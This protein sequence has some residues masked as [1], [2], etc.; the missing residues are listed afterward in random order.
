MGVTVA[1]VDTGISRSSTIALGRDSFVDG[2][3]KKIQGAIK[4]C[5]SHMEQL[6]LERAMCVEEIVQLHERS[7]KIVHE[8]DR[9]QAV[10]GRTEAFLKLEGVLNDCF[11]GIERQEIARDEADQEISDLLERLDDLSYEKENFKEWS[12]INPPKSVMVVE[13]GLY[14][15]VTVYGLHAKKIFKD[16]VT[17]TKICE[18]AEQDTSGDTPIYRIAT[19]GH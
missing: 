10:E 18:F 17:K 11:T 7:L 12:R 15:G 9:L 14:P 6:K 2:E 5:G 1:N 8:L 19:Y 3:L 13:G 4:S 16:K